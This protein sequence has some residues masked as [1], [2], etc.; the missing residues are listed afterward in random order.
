MSPSGTARFAGFV[1]TEDKSCITLYEK[2][3]KKLGV[4]VSELMRI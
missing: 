4:P 2:L 1:M 3:V